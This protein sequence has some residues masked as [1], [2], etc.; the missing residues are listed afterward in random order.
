MYITK[1]ALKNVRCFR[2]A[3]LNLESQ[4]KPTMW[5]VVVGDNGDGK[6]TLL[7][8]IA[9]GLCDESS[10]A[11]LHRELAGDFVRKGEGRASVEVHL[12]GKDNRHYVINTRIKPLPAFERVTQK[13]FEVTGKNRKEL[14]QGSFPWKEIFV[15]GYGAGRQTEGSENFRK[16]VAVDALY[17]LFWYTQPLQNPEL[18]WGRLLRHARRYPGRQKA[19]EAERKANKRVAELLSKVLML[20][21]PYR[22]SLTSE[23]IEGRERGQHIPLEA[24]GDGH[25]ATIAW[26]LDLLSWWLLYD[27]KQKR[28]V[29]GIVLV[30]ELEQHLHPK[31]QRTIVGLLSKHFPRIQ[32]ITTTHSPLCARGTADVTDKGAQLVMARRNADGIAEIV[33]DLPSLAGLRPDQ[34]LASE[35]F[36]YLIEASVGTEELLREASI[37][38]GKGEKRNR[39]E[40]A[41]YRKLKKELKEQ[42]VPDGQTG[43]EREIQS[44]QHQEMRSEIAE[45]EKRLFRGTR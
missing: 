18:V 30:D 29:T 13:V 36:G 10:A 19:D 25:R 26:V 9:M 33:A 20:K 32:F 38:A 12:R 42:L 35:V 3:T 24:L 14:D 23:G 16:Y 31:W 27:K 45:L 11:A 39:A 8:A 37:L 34:V 22:I 40:D 41:R 4:G 2:E 21:E 5:T 44:E 15:S 17:T 28:Q 1:V 43:I 7:R 6:T